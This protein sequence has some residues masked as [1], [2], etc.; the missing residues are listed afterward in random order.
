MNLLAA[1]NTPIALLPEAR[2]ILNLG[3]LPSARMSSFLRA[4][5]TVLS[6]EGPDDFEHD[7]FCLILRAFR[8]DQPGLIGAFQR[9][10]PREY[11]IVE[12]YLLNGVPDEYPDGRDA[13]DV[14]E[15]EFQCWWQAYGKAL[16]NEMLVDY[17][18]AMEVIGRETVVL[19]G[20]DAPPG[21]PGLKDPDGRFGDLPFD[22]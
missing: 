3:P 2:P 4:I 5:N 22:A 11:R 9:A 20:D 18:E 21:S 19:E 12:A 8:Q 10:F 13:A 7:L 15:E 14:Q 6:Q 1:P 17:N 16:Y